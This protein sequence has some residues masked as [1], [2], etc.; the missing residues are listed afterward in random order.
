MH[1]QKILNF[2]QIQ[3][4][5]HPPV[6]NPLGKNYNC[7][8][9]FKMSIFLSLGTASCRQHYCLVISFKKIKK[10]TCQK[11]TNRTLK[12][13]DKYNVN[14]SLSGPLSCGNGLQR[15]KIPKIT[16]FLKFEHSSLP[17]LITNENENSSTRI[18]KRYSSH[19]C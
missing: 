6:K 16:I 10:I 2:W 12:I 14:H 7:R 19:F 8:K 18:C 1:R 3:Y 5:S 11:L 15:L 13:S 4:N 17:T 9:Y